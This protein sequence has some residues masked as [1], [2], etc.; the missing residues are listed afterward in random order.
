MPSQKLS[1]QRVRY[2]TEA[3]PP[4]PMLP[5]QQP[6]LSLIASQESLRSKDMTSDIQ[7]SSSNQT[8]GQ[9]HK[10]NWRQK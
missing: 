2:P 7:A 8:R 5:N 1:L 9:F 4:K 6:Q 10:S 3:Q